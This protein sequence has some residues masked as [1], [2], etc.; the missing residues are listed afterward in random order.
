MKSIAKKL[1][2]VGLV[3]ILFVV[4]LGVGVSTGEQADKS[5]SDVSAF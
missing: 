4:C 1:Q 3:M 2:I 5:F